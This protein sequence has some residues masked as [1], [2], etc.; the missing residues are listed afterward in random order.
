MRF[1]LFTIVFISANGLPLTMFPEMRTRGWQD[2]MQYQLGKID[3][4][5][6]MSRRKRIAD[7]HLFMK[8]YLG[9]DPDVDYR[10]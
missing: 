2:L 8:K 7:P 9:D 3:E 5:P 4:K 10:K 6:Q 1:L